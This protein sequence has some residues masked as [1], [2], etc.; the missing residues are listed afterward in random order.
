MAISCGPEGGPRTDS[1]TNWYRVCISAAD[2][3]ELT[4][5]C[6]VC[7][8]SCDDDTGCEGLGA[9]SCIEEMGAIAVCGGRRPPSVGL[10]LP[11]CDAGRC[12]AGQTC[13]AGACR[14]TSEQPTTVTIDPSERY[15]ALIGFG[16]SLAFVEDQVIHHP[17]RDELYEAMFADLGLDVLRLRNRFGYAGDDDLTT[18]GAIV[19]AAE[20]SLGVAPTLV[21]TSWTPPAAL[22]ASGERECRGNVA[23][24]TLSRDTGGGFDYSGLAVHWRASLEAYASVGVVPEFIGIQN[25]PD[26]VPVAVAPGEGCRFLPAEGTS[27]ETVNGTVMDVE[28]PGLAETLDA[29]VAEL[30]GLPSPPRVVAPE[31]AGILTVANYTEALDTSQIGA[32]GHHLYDVDPTS[33]NREGLASLGELASD[34]DLPLL[35]TESQADGPGT[36]VLLHH[37]LVDEGVAGYLQ[38]VLAGP[39]SIAS[40]SPGMMIAMTPTDFTLEEAYHAVRHF[41]RYTDPGWIRVGAEVDADELLASAWLAPEGEALTV[42]IVNPGLADQDAR[43][44]LGEFAA[45]TSTVIRTVFDGVERSAELGPLSADG[46]VRVPGRAI[47]TLA[48]E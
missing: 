11:A 46:I 2:C 32:V 21:L 3:G 6:G 25:N 9:A 1:Q 29:V 23:T 22:K 16:A 38:G 10:C 7:T 37:S 24:C 35:Q 36:A 15:Q 31:T 19:G 39:A 20:E 42:V 18:A 30:A 26:F 27:T 33:V 41:A 48:I 5:L 45:G 14:P 34:L 17:R 13:V 4:C 12:S 43:V 8:R 47:V 28:Y 40:V 44:D